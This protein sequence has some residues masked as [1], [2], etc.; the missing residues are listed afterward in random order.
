MCNFE[1]VLFA[2]ADVFLDDIHCLKR[3]GA[4]NHYNGDF[5]CTIK[6]AHI[7]QLSTNREVF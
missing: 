6:D 2:S 5:T 1:I 4:R 7:W 3:R